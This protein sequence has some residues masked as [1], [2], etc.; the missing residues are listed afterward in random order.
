MDEALA[1]DGSRHGPA[2]RK[3]L[4]GLLVQTGLGHVKAGREDAARE[5]FEEA[6]EYDAGN[7]QALEQ[8]NRLRAAAAP[9]PAAPR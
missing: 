5:T 6:L 7:R 8:L 1:P 9:S 2:L 3:R 4:S